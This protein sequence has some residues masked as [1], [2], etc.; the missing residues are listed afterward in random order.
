MP[1]STR[2]RTLAIMSCTS[3][4]FAAVAFATTRGDASVA[5]EAAV[6]AASAPAKGGSAAPAAPVSRAEIAKRFGAQPANVRDTPIPG[7]YEVSEGTEVL[8]VSA[9]GNYMLSGELFEL[10]SR[11]NLTDA[12][13]A[14]IRKTLLAAVR[15]EDTIPFLAPK[16]KY[17]LYVFTDVDCAYCRRLH[18]HMAELNGM[19]ISVR[20]LAFPR[21]GLGTESAR[22]IE[23]VWCS[24]NRQQA[25]TTAKTGATVATAVAGC[26]N[27]VKAQYELGAAVGLEGT[28]ALYTKDGMNI[29]NGSPEEI[30]AQ[31]Q[32]GG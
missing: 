4:A 29:R 1:F 24:T 13:K 23:S 6:V 17:Q 26:K 27:P 9:D 32:K 20:Y 3:V 12:R 15:D 7:L 10:A 21:T 25:L 5:A 22:K 19:G 14:G 16:P 11:N 28:P 2:L 31:L 18:S 30:L 8:Y